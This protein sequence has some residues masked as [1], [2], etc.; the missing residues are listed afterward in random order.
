MRLAA[1]FLEARLA[2]GDARQ[3]RLGSAGKHLAKG[4]GLVLSSPRVWRS[5]MSPAC[6]RVMWTGQ[7]LRHRVRKLRRAA[8]LSF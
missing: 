4:A 2:V 5:L 1:M 3:A 7:V 8:Q 6:W